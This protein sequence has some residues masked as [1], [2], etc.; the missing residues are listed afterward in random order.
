MNFDLYKYVLFISATAGYQQSSAQCNV[1]EKYDK[2]I[3]GYH[4]SI[5]L[6]DDGTYSVWGSSMSKTGASDVTVP[7][8]INSTNYPALT[9]TILKAAL[10]GSTAGA[11]KDQGILLTSDGLWAWGILNSVVKNTIGTTAAFKKVTPPTG[12]NSFGL[13]VGVNPGDVANLFATYQSLVIRTAAGDVWMLTQAS[14]A[15][16]ANGGSAAS[17][18]SSAWKQ[19]KINSSTNL[20]NVTA[21]RGQVSSQTNNA[22]MAL[23]ATGQVY[24][25]GNS[26]YL[27]NGTA[28]SARNYATLMTLPVEF[29]ASNIPK[30][31]GVTG[32]IGSNSGTINTYYILS[33]AGNLYSLGDNSYRQCGDFTTTERTSWV[34]AKINSTTN[35]TNI[36]FFSAQEHNSS[37]P[38]IAVITTDG[39]LYTWGND[40]NAMLGRTD[41]GT[42]TGAISASYDPGAPVIFAPGTD[43][44]VSVEIGGHTMVY[45]KEGSSQFCYVGHRTN[46]SMGDGSTSSSTMGTYYASCSSTPSL[47]ICGYVPVSASLVNSDIAVSQTSIPADGTSTDTITIQLKDASGNNL[48]ASGGIVTI[49]TTNG[50]VG[51]VTDNNDGT[52]RVI[53][54]GP[55][56]VGTATISFLI[57]GR[58]A[59]STATVSFT[60]VLPLTWL[61]VAAY[62]Q[63]GVIKIKWATTNELNIKSFDIERSTNGIDWVVIAAGIAAENRAGNNDY[64]QNDT[65]YVSQKLFYR[66]RQ[67]DAEGH[68]SYSVIVSVTSIGDA[69]KIIVFPVPAVKAFFLANVNPAEIKHLKL[70]NAN[71]TAQKE[72]N[73]LQPRYDISNLSAGIYILFIEMKTGEIQTIRLIKN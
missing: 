17:A 10:G 61:Q 33:N 42:S 18:G 44:A 36:N 9:G 51:T 23:T 39:N 49:T 12:A 26:T 70:I 69:K 47:N 29:S 64:E 15:L 19:I 53:L 28:A 66:I 63:N 20:T 11:T 31:I 67:K 30:M 22:F 46:G 55:A 2:I 7:Q 50:T 37:Y 65:A 43:K 52:Y 57:N 13:P 48:T 4:S 16:E 56:S 1:N 58:A 32:G 73:N 68:Y 54:T 25:W 59:S 34:N 21:V 45:L 62:R 8:D 72:W 35:F 40:N 24:T 41:N 71:G 27:G 60:A 5:A 38:G 14:L 3:S 6:K